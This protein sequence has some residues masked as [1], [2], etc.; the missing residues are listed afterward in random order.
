MLNLNKVDFSFLIHTGVVDCFA[1]SQDGKRSLGTHPGF[2]SKLYF[3]KSCLEFD[4]FGKGSRHYCWC[5]AVKIF[6]K[7]LGSSLS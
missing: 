2:N 1:Y 5:R 4:K 7:I 3:I 6:Q